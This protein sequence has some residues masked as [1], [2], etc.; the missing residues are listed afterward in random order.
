[1]QESFLIKG[2]VSIIIPVYN[3]SKYLDECLETVTQQGYTNLEIILENDGSTDDSLLKCREWTKKD[4]RVK[5]FTHENWG[6]SKT[7]NHAID[8]CT[9]EYLAFVDADDMVASS[10]IESLVKTIETA[11]ADCAVV[12]HVSGSQYEDTMFSQGE[13]TTL[14]GEQC[15]PALFGRC[16]GFLW[17]KLYRMEIVREH[18][19]CLDEQTVI[20][21]DF[22][23][24]AQYFQYCK[25]MAI[26]DGVQYFYRQQNE[27]AVNRLDNIRWF[28]GI[29][30]YERIEKMYQ[31]NKQ[32]MNAILYAYANWL[33]ETR[34]RIKYI[35]S[36]SAVQRKIVLKKSMQEFDFKQQWS[37]KQK[38]KLFLFWAFPG[39]VMKYKRRMLK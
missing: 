2:L 37:A 15:F 14:T 21:E 9:G 17:N 13:I 18:K 26:N 38:V 22:L 25:T 12:Y 19:L 8:Q 39:A 4:S 10:F 20:M 29:Y 34:Y 35:E 1:M 6:V 3:A 24:N 30:V 23:F 36:D 27:S 16:Q 28:D 31:T 7:R 32:A 33:M 11:N 5:V